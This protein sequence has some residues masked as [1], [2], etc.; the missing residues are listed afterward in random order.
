M[1]LSTALPAPLAR[2]AAP[3]LPGFWQGWLGTLMA[4]LAEN[5]ELRALGDRELRDIG[6]TPG[7]AAGLAAKPVWRD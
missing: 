4:R 3:S 7:E 6:L 1:A 5:A 2:P